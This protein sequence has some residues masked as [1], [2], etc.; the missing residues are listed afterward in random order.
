MS[1]KS[2][3]TLRMC[4][5]LFCRTSHLMSFVY[6]MTGALEMYSVAHDNLH[7]VKGMH[8][9]FQIAGGNS[10]SAT[11]IH[12]PLVLRENSKGAFCIA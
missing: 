4:S 7:F 8:T 12:P 11:P 6:G 5:K 10:G 2:A 3:K 9:L 1:T